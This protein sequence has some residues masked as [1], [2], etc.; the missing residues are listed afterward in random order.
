M[1]NYFDVLAAEKFE[2]IAWKFQEVNRII[3]TAGVHL[4]V[5]LDRLDKSHFD[6]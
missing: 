6:L 5:P 3:V 2:L 1:L 4:N